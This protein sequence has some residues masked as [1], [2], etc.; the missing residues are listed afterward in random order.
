MTL[1]IRL[2]QIIAQYI[3][4]IF[5]PWLSQFV[6]RFAF[7]A[8]LMNYYWASA[9]TKIGES[10]WQPSIGAY[11]QIFPAATQAVSY[12]ASQLSGFYTFIVLLGTYAEFVLPALIV[13]GLFTRFAALG[14]IGFVFIQTLTDIYGHGVDEAT[15]GA[16]FDRASDALILDQRLLW[17]TILMVIFARG[18]G[19]LSLDKLFGAEMHT[20]KI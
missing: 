6:A 17:V 1:I 5:E 8:V 2:K 7:A 15:I 16:W 14:M 12:D 20:H 18:Y 13:F 11:Y 3:H 10:L 4:A 9:M 19:T